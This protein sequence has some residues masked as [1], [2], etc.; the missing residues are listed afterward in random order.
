MDFLLDENVPVSVRGVLEARGH[1]VRLLLDHAPG[2]SPDPIVAAVSER[3]ESVLISFDGDFEKI[4][5]RIPKGQRRRFRKLSR[6]WMQ[7]AEPRAAKRLEAALGLIESEYKL[8]SS[9]PTRLRIWL[10]DDYIKTH[11]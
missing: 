11:R 4:A 8:L 5:P 3:L 6:I 9:G 10:S 7:C 2:G 1:T